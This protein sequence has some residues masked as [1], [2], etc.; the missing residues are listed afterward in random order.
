MEKLK[1]Y[2]Y[3]SE[4]DCVLSG[5]RGN[6]RHL[7]NI[8]IAWKKARKRARLKNLRIHDLRRTVGSWMAN[9]GISITII[10]KVLNHN[11]SQSTKFYTHL[12]IYVV[13]YAIIVDLSPN[14]SNDL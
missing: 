13:R 9:F 5:K 11:D 1:Q 4:S 2:P 3:S 12:N 7:K 10:G 6:S 8:N 14:N